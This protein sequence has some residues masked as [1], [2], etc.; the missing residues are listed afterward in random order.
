MTWGS[1]KFWPTE[2]K[3]EG[4]W[5]NE[6]R[7][8]WHHN[9]GREREGGDPCGQS[10]TA[11]LCADYMSGFCQVCLHM[12]ACWGGNSL[13]MHDEEQ[14]D[15]AMYLH[16]LTCICIQYMYSYS[17][18]SVHFALDCMDSFFFKWIVLHYASLKYAWKTDLNTGPLSLTVY[19]LYCIW[20][21]YWSLCFV[22]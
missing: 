13:R 12:V 1:I 18:L 11:V 3:H 7:S 20:C 9:D 14:A 8:Q 19:V 16:A 21:I 17:T 2:I 10:I 22:M 4:M 15:S 6:S 5:A